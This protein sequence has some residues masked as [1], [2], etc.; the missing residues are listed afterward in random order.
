MTYVIYCHLNPANGKR[1]VGYTKATME[2]RFVNHCSFAKKGSPFLFHKAIRKYG[3]ECWIGT[4]LETVATVNEAREAE[5]KHILAFGSDKRNVGYNMTAGGEGNSCVGRKLSPEHRAKVVAALRANVPS[6]EQSAAYS[7]AR[8]GEKRS[9][10]GRLNIQKGIQVARAFGPTVAQTAQLERLH[11]SNSGLRRT[12][13]ARK[14]ISDALKGRQKQLK[15]TDAQIKEMFSLSLSRIELAQMYGIDV[16]TV[17]R[18]RQR[19]ELS[20]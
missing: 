15:L 7:A 4:V 20:T 12:E 16:G 1:Y 18:Y 3:T 11:E 5:K 2:S 6:R 19:F 13:E 10:V 9:D 14:N 8:R 17:T